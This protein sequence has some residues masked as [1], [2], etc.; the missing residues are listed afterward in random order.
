[1][2]LHAMCSYMKQPPSLLRVFIGVSMFLSPFSFLN[3]GNRKDPMQGHKNRHSTEVGLRSRCSLRP[4][5]G[6]LLC[7]V[8]KYLE[9]ELLPGEKRKKDHGLQLPFLPWASGGVSTAMQLSLI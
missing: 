5:K 8:G 7:E 2:N 3:P 6:S 9:E 4:R 1:M